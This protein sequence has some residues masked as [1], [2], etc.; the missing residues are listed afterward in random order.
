MGHPRTTA[1]S[2][3]A[4]LILAAGM[5]TGASAQ[6]AQE[7]ASVPRPTYEWDIQSRP[8]ATKGTLRVLI[9]GGGINTRHR[10]AEISGILCDRLRIAE[11]ATCTH[12]DNLDFLLDE[13]LRNYD[14]LL[15]NGWRAPLHGGSI[16]EAQK[17]GLLKF[18]QR[19]GGLVTTHVGNG[20][21]PDWPEFGKMVGMQYIDNAS[22]HTAEGPLAIVAP[23]GPEDAMAEVHP[24]T[25]GMS[26]F[27]IVDELQ[28]RLVEKAPVK[29]LA[30]TERPSGG[31]QP[32]AWTTGYGDGHQVFVT[33]LGH[34]AAAWNNESFLNILA[35]ALQW[36]A[37]RQV[38]RLPPRPN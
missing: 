34:G 23:P 35:G 21:F 19:G 18:M 4:A 31:N 26:R 37:K 3:A 24:I 38:E 17:A 13:S 14:A 1:L 11:L 6:Q 33:A 5:S 8:A 10:T 32:V 22:T 30:N 27:E 29:V 9:L 16:N 25:R 7:N 36:T 20:S 28:L 12:T 2:A 15:I